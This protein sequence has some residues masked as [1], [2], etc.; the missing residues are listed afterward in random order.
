MEMSGVVPMD[1]IVDELAELE[2]WRSKFYAD[3]E[4]R[5]LQWL[6]DGCKDPF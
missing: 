2:K 1:Y 5:R 4:A 3:Q 6:L